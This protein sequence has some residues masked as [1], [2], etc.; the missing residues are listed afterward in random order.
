MKRSRFGVKGH[1]HVKANRYW[2]AFLR[3]WSK[4][5]CLYRV[6]GQQVQIRAEATNNLYV[7]RQ[8]VATHNQFENNR[9]F[10][11]DRVL[12]RIVGI[13]RM[14]D[15]WSGDSSIPHAVNTFGIP[16]LFRRIV[17]TK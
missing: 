11:Y 16:G 7:A 15:V 1:F 5:P 10:L 8:A 17:L 12:N 4:L 13:F 3:C 2:L 14:N 6:A 9:T